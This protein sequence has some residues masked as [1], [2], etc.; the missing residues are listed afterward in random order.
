MSC[1]ICLMSCRISA[2][3]LWSLATKGTQEFNPLFC[4]IC[5]SAEKKNREFVIPTANPRSL[6]NEGTQEIPPLKK[7]AHNFLSLCDNASCKLAYIDAAKLQI[8]QNKGGAND[9]RSSDTPNRTKDSCNCRR[10]KRLRSVTVGR[11]DLRKSHQPTT[12]TLKEC[13]ICC[14]TMH[15]F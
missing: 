4:R 12:S 7:F 14:N 10:W 3:D 8:R 13:P 6:A 2:L 9:H 1:R 15:F 11:N 5:N